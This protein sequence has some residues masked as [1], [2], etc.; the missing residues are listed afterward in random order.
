MIGLRLGIHLKKR[1]ERRAIYNRAPG[2][3]SGPIAEPKRKLCTG[4][5]VR[6]PWDD[7][8]GRS[9]GKPVP[10]PTARSYLQ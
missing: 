6:R 5:I 4:D 9:V 10:W 2:K 8:V 1:E 3:K 7:S